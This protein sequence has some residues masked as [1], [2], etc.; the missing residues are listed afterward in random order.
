MAVYNVDENLTHVLLWA[1]HTCFIYVSSAGLGLSL[2]RG[3][4]GLDYNTVSDQ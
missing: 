2:G 3:T 1:V 4:A